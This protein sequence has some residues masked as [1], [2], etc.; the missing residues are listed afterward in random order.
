[1]RQK[2][3][4]EEKERRIFE[5]LAPLALIDVVPGSIRQEIPP[6]PD[7]LCEATGIGSIAIEL[8]ALDAE[9]TRK[10][11]QNLG[12]VDV[13][14]SRALSARPQSEQAEVTAQ[15]ADMW[16][17]IHFHE[18]AGTRVRTKI[19]T[20]VQSRLLAMSPTFE[21]H[22][23]DAHDMPAE[24][25]FAR[26][27]RGLTDGPHFS[28]SSAGS[29]MPPQLAKIRGKLVDKKPY[30]TNAPLELFAYSEHDE[31]DGHIDGLSAI[32]QCVKINLVG[33][34]FQRVTVFNLGFLQRVYR[35]P[36]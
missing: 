23:F 32:E 17:S 22:L 3:S 14:W 31:V 27:S 8:V 33:S 26:V 13:A 1:M 21:G 7:I 9:Y 29:W 24:V 36:E 6:A 34:Q 4:K 12:T 19:M 5:A 18:D 28:T 16:L 35:F 30:R 20:E 2:L 15:S 11:L 25:H 10:R